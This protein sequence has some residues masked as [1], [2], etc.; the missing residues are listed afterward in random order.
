MS[1]V[2]HVFLKWI[3]KINNNNVKN[4]EVDIGMSIDITCPYWTDGPDKNQEIV[5][6][7]IQDRG[8]ILRT[9]TFLYILYSSAPPYLYVCTCMY[10]AIGEFRVH[11]ERFTHILSS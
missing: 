10:R 11:L 4:L 7:Q 1:W 5:N 3:K 8:T 2:N 9:H 6:A